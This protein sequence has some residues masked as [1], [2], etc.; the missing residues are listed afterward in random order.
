MRHPI[1]E[2]QFDSDPGWLG[3]KYQGKLHKTADYAQRRQM[4]QAARHRGSMPP[5]VARKVRRAQ[6]A[7][8]LCVWEGAVTAVVP[9]MQNGRIELVCRDGRHIWAEQVVLA[10]GFDSARPGGAW[11]DE[12]IAANDLLVAPCGYPIVDKTLCWSPGLY[13]TGALAELEMGPI[14]ANIAGA[15]QAMRRLAAA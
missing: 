12:A 1:R 6:K 5:E 11:L 4:I 13:V 2:Y 9:T 3:P 10:T 15:R 7:G 14:A 8:E